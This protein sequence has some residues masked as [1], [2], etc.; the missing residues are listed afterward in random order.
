MLDGPPCIRVAL[1]ST[2]SK[3]KFEVTF[4][5]ISDYVIILERTQDEMQETSAKKK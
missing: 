1:N 5:L 3:H 2:K 4:F